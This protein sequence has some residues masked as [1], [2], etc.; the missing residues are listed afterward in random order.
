[1]AEART[2][3]EAG[4]QALSSSAAMSQPPAGTRCP[5]AFTTSS[6]HRVPTGIPLTRTSSASPQGM[7]V[8]RTIRPTCVSRFWPWTVAAQCWTAAGGRR[9]GGRRVRRA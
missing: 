9:P 2:D 6:S 5:R 8:Y 3:E 1:M 4:Y 7:G